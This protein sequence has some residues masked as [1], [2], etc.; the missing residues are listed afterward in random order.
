MF[1]LLPDARDGLPALAERV[2]S[3]SEFLDRHATTLVR[4]GEFLIPKFKITSGFGASGVLKKMG[5]GGVSDSLEIIHESV[6]EV[7]ENGTTVAAATCGR[8]MASSGKSFEPDEKL[9]FVADH[10]FMFLIREE[11]TRT[12]LF[13]GQVLNPLAG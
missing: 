4:V 1:W 9:D 11:E 3:E 13:M 5:L 7:D 2:C 10:P 8:L 12:V 6:I